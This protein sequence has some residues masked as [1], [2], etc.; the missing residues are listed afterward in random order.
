MDAVAQEDNM[1]KVLLVN[2]H[3]AQ[4]YALVRTLAQAGYSVKEAASG[5]EAL[6]LAAEA[7]D[8][9][10]LDVGLPDMSGFEVCRLLKA[11]PTTADIPVI[12]L[13]ASY[14]SSTSRDLGDQVGGAAYLF[15]PVDAATL[16]AVIQGA[17]ARLNAAAGSR[18][19]GLPDGNVT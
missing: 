18:A 17:L 13:S 12:F 4:R 11:E 15:Q 5:V 19:A 3:E 10:L 7:P 8:V 2:D 14:Q 6:G 9:I 1:V 16:W